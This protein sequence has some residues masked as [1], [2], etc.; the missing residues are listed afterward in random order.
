MTEPS[1]GRAN[2]SPAMS[3]W[4]NRTSGALCRAICN[5]DGEM[6]AAVTFIPA[7]LKYLLNL[8]APQQASNTDFT[9]QDRN[10]R[11]TFILAC[12]SMIS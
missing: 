7:L 9:P 4:M 5:I 1:T 3:D 10:I 6:S 12:R 11:T 8:P 2:C